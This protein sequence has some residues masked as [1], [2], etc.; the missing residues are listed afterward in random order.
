MVPV[1]DLF[2]TGDSS[3]FSSFASHGEKAISLLSPK[4]IGTWP[5]LF[6]NLKKKKKKKAMTILFLYWF[7]Y[8]HA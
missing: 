3:I 8:F 4:A 5:H 6:S 7:I 2:K 1:M